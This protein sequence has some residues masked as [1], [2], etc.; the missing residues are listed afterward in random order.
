VDVRN[1]TDLEKV[2]KENIFDVIIHLAAQVAVTTSVKNPRED[3]EINAFGT[4]NL[5]ECVR[6]YSPKS[7]LIYSS[8]NKV[9]GEFK[10]EIV[11]EEF[12]YAYKEENSG[13]SEDQNLDFHS[14]YGCSKGTADQY[15]RDYSRIYNLKTV[16][17]RQSCIYGP[18]QFGIEDQG[19]VSWFSISSIFNKEF[20]IY[21]NGKQVRDVLHV[22][23]LI[24][25]YKKI[26]NNA[27]V[28][29]GKIYNIGGGSSNKMS[30]LE[31]IQ[32]ISKKLDKDI[33]YNYSDWR[34]GDQ[35]IYVSDITR[36]NKDIGWEPKITSD[37]GVSMMIDWILENKEILKKL[38]IVL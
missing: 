25:L 8:T 27:H 22:F 9:Y 6:N 11:E 19:W 24:S 13:I 38:K 29:A 15:V 2:F 5:I 34:P 37:N 17:L 3:F 30:L 18:N 35:K 10:S 20:T 12:R 33:V 14:P 26:I 28:C 1:H 23:D 21:G 32:L 7:L 16:V 36:I 31:L 4:F